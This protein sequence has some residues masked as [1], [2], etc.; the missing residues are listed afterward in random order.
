MY[1]VHQYFQY[2]INVCLYYILLAQLFI[3]D[4]ELMG[5]IVGILANIVLNYKFS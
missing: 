3:C 1:L 2:Y 4:N 5:I